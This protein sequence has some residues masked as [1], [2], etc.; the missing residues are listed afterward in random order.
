MYLFWPNYR[1]ENNTTNNFYF[2][3]IPEMLSVYRTKVTLYMYHAETTLLSKI[4]FIVT[5]TL[6]FDPK[7][8]RVLPLPQGNHAVFEIR[9]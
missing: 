7:I 1:T 9:W 8:N 2:D 5:V 3:K 4:L 6:T